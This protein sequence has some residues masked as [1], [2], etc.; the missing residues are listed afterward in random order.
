MDRDEG[1]TPLALAPLA[2]LPA[3]CPDANLEHALLHSR[4]ASTLIEDGLDDLKRAELALAESRASLA[5]SQFAL[6]QALE[7][8]TQIRDL[9]LHDHLTGLPNRQLFEDRLNYAIALAARREW[10]L[11]VIFLDLDGFKAINDELGHSAGDEVLSQTAKRLTLKVRFADTVCRYGGDEFVLL[12]MNP[13]A[14]TNIERI[15][16]EVLSEIA[17]PMQFGDR[18]LRVGA[19]L[20]IAIYPDHGQDGMK[21]ISDADAAMYIAK[22]SQCRIA[23]S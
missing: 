23:F 16:R 17:S 22:K 10:N 18:E 14:R 11:A 12:L 6:A 2:P 1:K 3:E 20:G 4:E 19:S 5:A 8:I 15:A 13:Q 21:L 7:A 9:A